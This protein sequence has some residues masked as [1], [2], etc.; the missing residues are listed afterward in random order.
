MINLFKIV[1]IIALYGDAVYSE[2]ANSSMTNCD[3]V[4]NRDGVK[5][6]IVNWISLRVK[7]DRRRFRSGCCDMA[8]FRV[9]QHDDRSGKKKKIAKLQ[10]TMD[11]GDQWLK[12]SS[13]DE[14][15]L[16]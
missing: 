7:K 15:K 10:N 13:W 11:I 5:Y 1:V 4:S 12:T 3:E 16:V 8:L 2:I 14:N 9:L 6:I